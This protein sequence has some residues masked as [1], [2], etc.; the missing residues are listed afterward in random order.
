MAPATW[1]KK[2]LQYFYFHVHFVKFLRKSL[3]TEHLP[4][5]TSLCFPEQLERWIPSK[6]I[7]L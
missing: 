3:L 4:A 1:L 5:T 2:R 7:P 6:I